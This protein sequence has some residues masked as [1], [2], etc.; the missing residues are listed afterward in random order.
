MEASIVDAA[1]SMESHDV[2]RLVV[3]GAD[4]QAP[5]GVVSVSDLVRVIGDLR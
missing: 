3:S 4:D 5:V 1:R 2:H